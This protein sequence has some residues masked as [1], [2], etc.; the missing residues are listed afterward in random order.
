VYKFKKKNIKSAKK[1]AKGGKLILS[2]TQY[3]LPDSKEKWSVNGKGCGGNRKSM[4]S[5][6]GDQKIAHETE[7]TGAGAG[8]AQR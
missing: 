4:W 2:Q 8:N 7:K 6:G 1:E 3:V 5:I